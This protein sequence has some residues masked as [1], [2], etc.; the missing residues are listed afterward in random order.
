VFAH[1]RLLACIALCTAA[2]VSSAAPAA[3]HPFGPPSTA[4]VVADGSTVKLS[5]L[6][7]EDDWVALGQ[8]LGAFDEVSAELTGEERLQQSTAVRDYLLEKITV[9]QQ[10]Q[11]CAGGLEALEG[12]LTRGARFT[13][14][15]P[16]TVDEIDLTLGAL[17]DLNESYRTVLTP[18]T[19]TSPGQVM[20]TAAQTTQHLRFTATA[21]NRP[22]AVLTLTIITAAVVLVGA[23]FV[24]FRVLRR[25][26]VR[27]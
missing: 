12:L 19:K 23:G 25:R 20:F 26:A 15:C 16:A 22:A 11:R 10:G 4:Q 24:T 5:W 2:L 9:S 7:A 18:E 17:T 6:A 8:S 3:A 13:F 27:A 1:H 21:G 14:T